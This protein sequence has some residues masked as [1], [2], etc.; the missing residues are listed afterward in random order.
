MINPPIRTSRSENKM[1]NAEIDEEIALIKSYGKLVYPIIDGYIINLDK[2]RF[3]KVTRPVTPSAL[4]EFENYLETLFHLTYSAYS[5]QFHFSTNELIDISLA[6]VN[7]TQFLTLHT[8]GY[9]NVIDMGLAFVW[10]YNSSQLLPTEN[11]VCLQ[12]IKG[13]IN[14][15]IYQDAIGLVREYRRQGAL[16]DVCR[17]GRVNLVTNENIKNGTAALLSYAG[18]INSWRVPHIVGYTNYAR[19]VYFNKVVGFGRNHGKYVALDDHRNGNL[20]FIYKVK[21]LYSKYFLDF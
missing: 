8:I 3:I 18:L 12:L 15:S 14:V 4:R 16:G 2:K 5:R 17:I 7:R 19:F 1:I 11:Q 6:A 13:Q 20:I 9:E 10:S 21:D